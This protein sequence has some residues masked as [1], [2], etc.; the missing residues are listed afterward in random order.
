[1]TKDDKKKAPSYEKGTWQHDLQQ[2]SALLA[3][4]EANRKKAGEL[5]YNGAT[6]A[7]NAW[8]PGAD[9]DA[10]GEGLQSEVLAALGENYKGTASK[11]KTIAVAVHQ[12]GLVFSDYPS[13][14]KAYAAAIAVT[15]TAEVEAEEDDAAEKAIEEIEV[16]KST[17]TVD[18]AAAILLSRGV[19]GAVVAILDTL[20]ADNEAA[21]RS[22][23]RAV[24][25]EVSA[26]IDAKTKAERDAKEAEKKAEREAREA[27][28]AAK[29]AE[30][31]AAAKQKAAAKKTA[32]KKAAA[33]KPK[34]E[35]EE[36]GDEFDEMFDDLDVETAPEPAT[37][38][39]KGVK[40]AAAKGK[41]VVRRPG[42]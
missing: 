22:F 12:K 33:P 28:R 37:V 34:P 5:L 26:R 10:S 36:P 4:S 18:G 39:P 21:H 35:V 6:A 40:K 31:E 19:D 2:S 16:P 3:R 29:A 8:L 42:R 23:L 1:M 15:K 32:A 25:T 20:G 9:K 17:T 11:I 38:A 14:A 27:E 41:P 30:K 13:I 7:I 24:T